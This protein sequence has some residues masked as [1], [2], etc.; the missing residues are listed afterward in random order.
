MNRLIKGLIS[1][2]VSVSVIMLILY[3]FVFKGCS[4]SRL[5]NN[6]VLTRPTKEDAETMVY[7][8]EKNLDL[9]KKQVEQN[10]ELQKKQTEQNIELQ[11]KADEYQDNREMEIIDKE[12]DKVKKQKIL[13]L[14]SQDHSGSQ[15]DI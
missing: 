12:K 7:L 6:N 4:Q 9:Q 11:K 14:I 8:D 13:N 2:V 3:L 1:F 15:Y 10:L 5:L